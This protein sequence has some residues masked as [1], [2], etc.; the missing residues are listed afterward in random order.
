MRQLSDIR[1]ENGV[2]ASLTG[3]VENIPCEFSEW[4]RRNMHR[5]AYLT[6]LDGI[7]FGYENG[8]PIP[9][10][11]MEVKESGWFLFGTASVELIT[12]TAERLGV[13]CLLV[14]IIDSNFL[15]LIVVKEYKSR[16]EIIELGKTKAKRMT[17][18]SFK[19]AVE[20]L[21]YKI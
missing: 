15:E 4:W 20:K 2:K 5:K 6:D 3:K 16:K 10:A 21:I 11:C 12:A 13:P 1:L 7:L 8:K 17:Y 19:E 9:L 18:Q 14:R